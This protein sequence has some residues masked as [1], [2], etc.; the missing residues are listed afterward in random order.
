[1]TL[2]AIFDALIGQKLI[3][4]TQSVNVWIYQGDADESVSG[5]SWRLRDHSAMGWLWGNQRKAIDWVFSKVFKQAN[6]CKRTY[7]AELLK[8]EFMK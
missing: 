8:R 6:H 7:D 1:M 2:K 5:R 4:L 3:W